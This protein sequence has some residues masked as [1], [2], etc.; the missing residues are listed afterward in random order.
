V[1]VIT[2]GNLIF[3]SAYAGPVRWITEDLP[4][5]A[6]PLDRTAAVIHRASPSRTRIDTFVPYGRVVAREHPWLDRGE[7]ALSELRVAC[8]RYQVRVTDA[9]APISLRVGLPATELG[10]A[11]SAVA[12]A[13][14]IDL[15]G[16]RLALDPA[17]V[18]TADATSSTEIEGS[19]SMPWLCGRLTVV[20]AAR[21]WSSTRADLVLAPASGHRLRYPRR[22]FTVGFA[23][24]DELRRRFTSTG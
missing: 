18:R 6:A 12:A 15:D 14:A 22:W 21:P 8:R 19:L 16:C 13:G 5:Y 23:F 10:A 9:N 11:L 20:A 24:V 1:I 7:R 2:P 4:P 17:T 3:M